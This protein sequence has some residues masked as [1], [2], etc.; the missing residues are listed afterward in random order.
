MAINSSRYF[1]GVANC[2][3]GLTLVLVIMERAKIANIEPYD[4]IFVISSDIISNG[5]KNDN[6]A[7]Q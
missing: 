3:C 5:R 4:N 1:V 2:F 7:K 6:V